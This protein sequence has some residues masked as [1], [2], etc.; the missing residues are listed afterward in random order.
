MR[1]R[2]VAS[3]SLALAGPMLSVRPEMTICLA[4]GV[5]ATALSKAT[6]SAALSDASPNLKCTVTV[7]PKDCSA[8]PNREGDPVVVPRDA[9]MISSPVSRVDAAGGGGGTSVAFLGGGGASVLGV[10]AG[11]AGG[12][13]RPNSAWCP[14]F[15]WARCDAGSAI[16][17]SEG[18]SVWLCRKRLHDETSSAAQSGRTKR[19]G[20]VKEREGDLVMVTP[21]RQVAW[22]RWL[23]PAPAGGEA[24]PL[25]RW[26]AGVAMA[27]A[28]RPATRTW[29]G[30][31]CRPRL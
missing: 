13:H 6:L 26:R 24:L 21:G 19:T 16:C 25:Q 30:L 1:A 11:Q 5:A 29:L 20:L 10:T 3:N 23:V 27:V 12:A 18:V 28:D 14:K 22:E 17:G 2:A 15:I 4:S 7:L 9:G 8:C 31:D